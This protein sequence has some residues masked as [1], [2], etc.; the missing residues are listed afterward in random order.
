MKKITLSRFFLSGF[1]GVGLSL[2]VTACGLGIHEDDDPRYSDR[3]LKSEY[4]AFVTRGIYDGNLG[5]LAGADSICQTEASQ[6]RLKRTYRAY[7]A[8]RDNALSDRFPPSP[9][10]VYA[11]TLMGKIKVADQLADM[12]EHFNR[13]E[14]RENFK[15]RFDVLGTDMSG[16]RYWAGYDEMGGAGLSADCEHWTDTT[17]QAS[18]RSN[19]HEGLY[20]G[21]CTDKINLVCLS[22]DF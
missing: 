12:L 9:L 16:L 7:L 3:L 5:G 20:V 11:V 21:E 19:Y 15:L 10:P 4:R 6:N 2:V 1:L 13:V 22:T 14:R 18:S 8:D 17:G